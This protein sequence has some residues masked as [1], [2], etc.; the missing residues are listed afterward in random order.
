[1]I[2]PLRIDTDESSA[3]FSEPRRIGEL[4]PQLLAQRG[5]TLPQERPADQHQIETRRELDNR[6]LAG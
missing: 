2:A 5:I 4:L 1:M 6:T 3:L